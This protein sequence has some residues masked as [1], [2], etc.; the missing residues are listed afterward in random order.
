MADRYK[1]AMAIAMEYRERC[2]EMSP[3][4]FEFSEKGEE[5]R[6]WFSRTVSAA[7]LSTAWDSETGNEVSGLVLK[8]DPQTVS[9]LRRKFLEMIREPRPE[10]K[11]V[12]DEWR[13]LNRIIDDIPYQNALAEDKGKKYFSWRHGTYESL[14]D[15]DH[16]M[17]RLTGAGFQPFD[18]GS[19]ICIEVF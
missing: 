2:S 8:H 14:C 9:D 17:D 19:G 4:E 3:E 15:R 11:G 18:D 1:M 16:F 12:S 10:P 7:L 13:T 6:R 5:L